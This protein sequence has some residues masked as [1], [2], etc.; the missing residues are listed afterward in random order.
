MKKEYI[1]SVI[2]VVLFENDI[3][4]ESVGTDEPLNIYN[5]NG[6]GS[7]GSVGWDAFN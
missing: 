1:E 5:N 7:D 3:I 6:V 2:S 4:T